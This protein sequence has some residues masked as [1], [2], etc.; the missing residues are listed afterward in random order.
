[1][2]RKFKKLGSSVSD[3][4][5]LW[6]LISLT[7]GVAF[8]VLTVIN[9]QYLSASTQLIFADYFNFERQS[10]FD[11]FFSYFVGAIPHVLLLVIMGLCAV[12]KP[13]IYATVFLNGF[14]YG[15]MTGYIFSNY[16]FFGLI[17]NS[18]VFLIPALT[19]FVALLFMARESLRFSGCIFKQT[20]QSDDHNIV[21]GDLSLF[22]F[23]NSA[24]TVFMAF[25]CLIRALFSR[26]LGDLSILNF[27]WK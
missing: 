3:K 6:L 18:V 11:Y 7:S 26:F 17:Y 24:F 25:S 27:G 1:M 10:I 23:R 15:M 14:C 13:F 12:G 19:Y 9:N 2:K 22:L 20:C 8:G 16:K 21:N 4:T 5:V